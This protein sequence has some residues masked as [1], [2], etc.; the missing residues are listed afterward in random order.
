MKLPDPKTGKSGGAVTTNRDT[1]LAFPEPLYTED[2]AALL[3]VRRWAVWL[4]PHFVEGVRSSRD[5]RRP[6]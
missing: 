3:C 1:P 6:S 2:L 5:M 4:L